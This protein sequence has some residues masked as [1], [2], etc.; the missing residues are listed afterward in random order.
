MAGTPDLFVVCKSC[1]SEVSPYITECPYCG[2]RLR[3]RAPKIE[4]EDGEARV[5]E[6]RK[7]PRPTLGPLRTGEIPGIRGDEVGRPYATI[8]LTVLGIAG[9]LL[10]FLVDRV[11][12][13][14]DGPIDGEWW[15]VATSPFL[16]ENGWAQLA[17]VTAIALYGW[18]LE[19]RHGPVLVVLLFALG[20][21]G[22]T[23]AAVALQDDPVVLGGNGAAMALIGAWAIPLV[24]ARRRGQDD[25]E[26]D[27]LGT[28]VIAA[29]VFLL[30]VVSYFT[31]I[32][33]GITGALVGLL[34][35]LLLSRLKPR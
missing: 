26:A 19:R 29:V 32:V 9:Y 25:D 18:L 22:G 14:V 20:G 35:G 1:G 12:V 6:S 15:R 34:A 13:A 3:K 27:L 7:L 21:V 11:S 5:K 33:A 16:Y 8:I 4:R 10:L 17:A 2:Q 24:L 30:P 31:S 23:A 28:A